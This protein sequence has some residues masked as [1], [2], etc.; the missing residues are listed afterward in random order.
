MGADFVRAEL[1]PQDVRESIAHMMEVLTKQSNQ[2]KQFVPKMKSDALKQPQNIL[3][4]KL[5]APLSP[6]RRHPEG[7]LSRRAWSP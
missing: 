5:R 4:T 2:K 6:P 3:P 7:R 1:Q